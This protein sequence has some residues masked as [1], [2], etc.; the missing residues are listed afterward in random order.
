M[1]FTDEA[2]IYAQ[3]K[4]VQTAVGPLPTS[5]LLDRSWQKARERGPAKVKPDPKRF[6]RFQRR[7]Y[8]N[9]YGIYPSTFFA[10]LSRSLCVCICVGCVI[11]E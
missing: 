9:S 7:L 11:Q 5:P 8:R 3:G 2:E 1:G 4:T 6:N 10:P